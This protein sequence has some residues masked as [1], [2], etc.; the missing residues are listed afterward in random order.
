VD[1]KWEREGR[2]WWARWT[3][4]LLRDIVQKREKKKWGKMEWWEIGTAPQSDLSG[5]REKK[6]RGEEANDA[7]ERRAAFARDCE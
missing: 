6:R 7:W 2:E 4:L 1:N 5:K 3:V